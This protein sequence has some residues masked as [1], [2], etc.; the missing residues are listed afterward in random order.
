[1]QML[2]IGV[3]VNGHAQRSYGF[4]QSQRPDLHSK[5]ARAEIP[6]FLVMF[7]F[8]IRRSGIDGA[9]I[10]WSARVIVDAAVLYGMVWWLSPASAPGI[11]RLGWTAGTA[12]VVLG[13]ASALSG[14][15][16]KL[17]FVLIILLGYAIAMWRVVLEP[18][19]RAVLGARL[20]QLAR[21][22]RPEAAKARD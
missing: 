19:E 14:L 16:V 7:V 17:L 1:M 5:L 3:L 10:A 20:A 21:L 4:V 15:G 9:A 6:V 22:A 2:T 13:A 8:L 12:V 18:E 11:R